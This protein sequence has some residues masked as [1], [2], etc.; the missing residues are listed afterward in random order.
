M[1]A[2]NITEASSRLGYKSRTVLNRFI[3]N[4][5]LNDFLVVNKL[6]KKRLK[7]EGL[8]EH[9]E[10][11]IQ[12]RSTSIQFRQKP[13]IDI[14]TWLR[15]AGTANELMN[16]MGWMVSSPNTMAEWSLIYEAME[17]ARQGVFLIVS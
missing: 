8:K 1:E 3:S 9:V 17:K 12:P 2:V 13:D 10:S 11:L 6:G 5:W 4:G 16:E 15:M 14:D 7:M